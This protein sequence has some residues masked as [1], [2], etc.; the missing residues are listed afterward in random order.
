MSKIYK[1]IIIFF[2][3]FSSI[4]ANAHVQH[5]ENLNLLEFDLYRNNKNIG[6][7]TFSFSKENDK[8]IVRSE[9]NFEIKKLGIVLYKY[10]ATGDEVYKD[11]KLIKFNSKTDQNGKLKYVNIKLEEDQFLIDGSSN[12]GKFSSDFVIG[13]WW[14]HV[15]VDAKTQISAVSGRIIHQKVEFLGKEKISL[16]NKTYDTLHFNFKS[17]DPKLSKDK[18]INI[19]IWYDEKTLNWVK[20]SF[21]KK[22]TW[23]YRLKTVK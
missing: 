13:T 15:I 4:S 2:F 18:K 17:T 6:T 19:D 11:G 8:L 14:N 21:K 16:D 5:Y 22:G 7:H 1:K 9:I 23:E 12:K 20:S 10:N 3:F